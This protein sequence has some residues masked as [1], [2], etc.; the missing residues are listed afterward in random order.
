MLAQDGTILSFTDLKKAQWYIAKGLATVTCES[1]F[2]IMLNFEPSGRSMQGEENWVDDTYYATDRENKCVCC[3]AKDN[4]SRFHVVPTLY[5]THFP[6][7]LKSHRSHD[8]L[9]LCFDCHNKASRG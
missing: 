6:D 4:F 8:V 9:L 7:A 5:R 1:P 2:T 3:G